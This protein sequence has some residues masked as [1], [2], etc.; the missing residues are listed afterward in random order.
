MA[1]EDGLGV[2]VTV[3]VESDD[4]VMVVVED[5]LPPQPWIRIARSKMKRENC[6]KRGSRIVG[7]PV[8]ANA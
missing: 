2:T 8:S 4:P 6:A 5:E 3:G 1:T 7:P